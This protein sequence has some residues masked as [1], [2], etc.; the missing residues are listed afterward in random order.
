MIY[1]HAA[2]WGAILFIIL[3]QSLIA[4]S[5]VFLTEGIERFQSGKSYHAFLYFYL[6]AMA[7]PYIPGCASFLFL[8]RWINEAHRMF[9]DQIS[10]HVRGKVSQYRDSLKRERV[11]ATIARNALPVLR[12]YITFVHDLISFALNSLLS[13]AA[14]VYVLPKRLSFG[15]VKSCL[16]CFFIILAFRKNIIKASSDCELR[17]LSY[18]KVLDKTWD[19]LAIGN[20]HNETIWRHK[21]DRVGSKFY[22]SAI[23]LQAHRQIGNIMLASASLLPTVFLVIMLLRGGATSPPVVAAIVVNLTRIFLILNSLSALVYKVLDLSAMRAKLKVLFSPLSEFRGDK[24]CGTDY[25]D[26]IYVN[27]AEAHGQPG[28][29]SCLTN[30]G[31]GR[32]VVT[33]ANGSGKS[34][35]LLTMKE[36]L[37][38]RCFLMPTNHNGLLWKDGKTAASTGQRMVS[39]LKEIASIGEVTHILLDEWDANLDPHN[40]EIINVILNEIAA[41]KTVVEVRHMRGR[42]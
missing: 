18:T 38:D 11:N 20:V 9:V 31:A 8:Q 14:I 2:A 37:G 35:A 30:M 12:E 32:F 4:A 29:L 36:R 21:K 28:V 27:G 23:I 16:L 17:Y 39:L 5:V 7:L 22:R 24:A 25:I 13:M 19:N 10:D 15:Y 34:S 1:G 41:T 3:H 33:G 26:T 40:T 6:A 42:P